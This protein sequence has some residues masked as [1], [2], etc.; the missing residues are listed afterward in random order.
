MEKQD[1]YKIG[2]V[3]KAHGLKGEVTIIVTE[4]VDLDPIESVFI[5]QKNTLVPYFI[6]D[7]SDRGDK[8][9]VK[10]EEI[11]SIEQANGLKGCSLYLLKEARPKLKRGEFYDDEIVG[12]AVE[13][14]LT[15]ILGNITEVSTNGP[16]KLLVVN[17]LG[18]E[19]LI[20]TNGPFIKSVNKTKKL[21]KV[22]L[23]E[24]FLDI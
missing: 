9:F 14:E 24:G 6:K 21:V 13:D 7:L 3:A 15:G 22:E 2:Y 20:P 4:P 11:N 23:P 1:C 19:A 18:K 10:F 16:N 17:Y 12:F 8:A 5:E